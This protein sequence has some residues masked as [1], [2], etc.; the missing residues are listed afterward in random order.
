MR[1]DKMA[2][3]SRAKEISTMVELLPDNEQNLA[4]ELIKRMVLAW[5]SDFTKLTPAERK[6]LEEA[7]NDFNIGNT[8]SHN[9]ID[10]N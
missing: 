1:G 10:W 2:V 6:R 7:E 4:Y 9:D 8:V 3:L 5:D